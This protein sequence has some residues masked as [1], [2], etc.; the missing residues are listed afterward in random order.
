MMNLPH[1]LYCRSIKEARYEAVK[2]I[3][4]HG[5]LGTDERGERVKYV[6]HLLIAIPCDCCEEAADS[7]TRLCDEAFAQNL[8]TGKPAGDGV[9]AHEYTYGEEIHADD[10]LERIIQ[11]L[12]EHPETRRA[13]IPIF[14]THHIGKSEVPCMITTV[15]DIEPESD[16]DYLNL[17]I[18]GRSNESAIAMKSDNKG[19]SEL[20]K[21]VAE[22][23]GVKAGTIVL[24]DVN[25]H[26]RVNSDMD[27]IKRIL[28]EGAVV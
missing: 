15:Y 2:Y 24:H 9:Q 8:I 5:K 10:G 11:L 26:C 27:E 18:L 6:K 17:T 12:I 13:V 7:L 14:K 1:V 3:M 28:S 20:L 19:Y 16:D 22:R 4:N 21:Y 25:L 23:V